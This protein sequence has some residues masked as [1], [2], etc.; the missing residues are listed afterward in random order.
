MDK[1]TGFIVSDTENV[2]PINDM[3]VLKI[4]SMHRTASAARLISHASI[5]FFC[6]RDQWSINDRSTATLTKLSKI[7]SNPYHIKPLKLSMPK[8]CPIALSW[9]Y[10]SLGRYKWGTSCREGVNSICILQGWSKKSFRRRLRRALWRPYILFH[11]LWVLGQ[12]CFDNLETELVY[13]EYVMNLY[14]G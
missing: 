10:Q 6:F 9:H 4:T 8:F 5:L 13:Y 11:E 7:A 2:E 3:I 14:G 12:E 1:N